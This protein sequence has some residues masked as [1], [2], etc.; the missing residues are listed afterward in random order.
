MD[1]MST[2][3]GYG[4]LKSNYDN[5][6]LTNLLDRIK[7]GFKK[8]T[9]FNVDDYIDDDAIGSDKTTVVANYDFY[10]NINIYTIDPSVNFYEQSVKNFSYN[11]F[12]N[13]LPS[14]FLHHKIMVQSWR[15][16]GGVGV[17]PTLADKDNYHYADCIGVYLM[18]TELASGV[19]DLNEQDKT[20]SFWHAVPNS[21]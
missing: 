11:V 1:E 13:P 8:I 2:P 12:T 16:L 19:V 5:L 4:D 6:S 7:E 21:S 10:K 15:T 20:V 17:D 14:Y 18:G 3:T 9:A